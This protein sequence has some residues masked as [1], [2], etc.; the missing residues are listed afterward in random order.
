MHGRHIR[1]RRVAIGLSPGPTGP[2]L[3]TGAVLKTTT[4]FFS[5]RGSPRGPHVA[6][7][8]PDRHLGSVNPKVGK[9]HDFANLGVHTARENRDAQ[10]G[11]FHQHALHKKAGRITAA[12]WMTNDASA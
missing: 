3:P 10:D 6:L 1:T 12:R 5:P 7:K 11:I 4:L 9:C 8:L 2:A